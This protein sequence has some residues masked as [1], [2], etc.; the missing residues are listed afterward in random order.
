MIDASGATDAN[1]SIPLTGMYTPNDATNNVIRTAMNFMAFILVLGFT[2]VMSPVIYNEYVIG[3]IGKDVKGQDKMNRIRSID[4]YICIVFILSVISLILQGIRSNNA[5]ATVIGFLVGVFFV[6]SFVIIQSQKIG[7]S[8]FKRF[9]GDGQK[10]ETLYVNVSILDDF[11]KFLY[12]NFMIFFKNIL[13][14]AV[15]FFIIVMF[16]YMLGAFSKDGVFKSGDLIIY[17]CLFTIYLTI[18]IKTIRDGAE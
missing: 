9:F 15:V 7:P 4:V 10:S 2:Y 3:L 13:I 14:G 6:I 8:W 5:A 16:F 17:L 18:A 12:E 1:L 11:F